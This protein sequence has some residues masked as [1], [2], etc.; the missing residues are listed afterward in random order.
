[1]RRQRQRLKFTAAAAAVV[2]TVTVSMPPINAESSEET[3]RDMGRLG[4]HIVG[5]YW[6]LGSNRYVWYTHNGIGFDPGIHDDSLAG[7]TGIQVDL[8]PGN[9][10]A[11]QVATSTA[12]AI[13]TEGTYGATAVSSDVEITGTDTAAA[14]PRAWDP[15][16]N[17]LRGMQWST[18]P[19][20]NSFP[21]ANTSGSLLTNLPNEPI[22]ISGFRIAAGAA[23]TSQMTVA[24]YQGGASDTDF[25]GAALVGVVGVT[26]GSATSA[27]L[28]APTP[29]PFALDP[30]AGRVWVFWM[31]APG[32]EAVY[33]L[34]SDP[35]PIHT[36]AIATSDWV[37]TGGQCTYEASSIALSSD[38]EDWPSTL[39]AVTG[40][41]VGV[42]SIAISYT[43]VAGFQCNMRVVGRIGTRAAANTFAGTSQ[44][45]LLV[46]NSFT[47]PANL[48]MTIQMA[49]VNY[50]VHE[51]GSHYRLSLA[52]GGAANDNFSG[53]SFT[54]IGLA[55]GSATGWVD[56]TPTAG[57][58]P[59]PPSSRAFL[60]IHHTEGVPPS[61]LAFDGGAPDQYGPDN[62]PA[63][64]YNGNTSESEV[65]DGSLGQPATTNVTF[66]ENVAQSG[67]IVPD[68]FNYT[69][70]NNVGVRG[71]WEVLG[72]LVAA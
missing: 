22:I 51:P 23:H 70:D 8:D 11:A 9:R 35:N 55:G 64:Y 49:S 20:L 33:P 7:R 15:A 41:T 32:F 67:V 38:P 60:T 6:T 19:G 25:Q 29:T 39:P 40:S 36:A 1:M 24:I 4:S 37:V 12:A 30:S 17:G 28:F 34:T 5:H 18:L 42:P 21:N 54:D 50:A 16:A 52:I 46:G 72:F 62:N 31:H 13:E 61:A 44:A 47:T 58:I 43:T 3:M 2:L 53:A 69:N 14:G 26:S 57:S 27:N 65:D 45:T 56:V 68:G 71:F 59:L 66:D 10:T 63:A 48:G